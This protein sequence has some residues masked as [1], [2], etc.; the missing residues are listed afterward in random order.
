MIDPLAAARQ[1]YGPDR[2]GGSRLILTLDVP[3]TVLA[4]HQTDRRACRRGLRQPLRPQK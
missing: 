1:K 3:I 4:P 2:A